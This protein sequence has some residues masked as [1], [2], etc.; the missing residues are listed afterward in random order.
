METRQLSLL[1]QSL[2]LTAHEG[3]LRN[4]PNLTAHLTAE[5]AHTGTF[6]F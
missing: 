3:N 5:M 4:Y 1:F 6:T 2:E